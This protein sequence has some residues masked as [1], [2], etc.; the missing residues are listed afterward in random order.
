MTALVKYPARGTSLLQSIASVYTAMA[1]L[2]TINV[3]GEKST[4]IPAESLDSGIT[5]TKMS[6]G[7]ADPAQIKAS[8][9]YDPVHTTYTA[10]AGIIATPATTNF[11]VTWSDAATTSAIYSC[12]GAALDKKAEIGKALMADIT[13]EISGPAT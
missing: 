5:R 6:D 4:T 8:G 3:T 2:T 10:L 12:V 1:G 11:K 13:L 9:F 7:Y